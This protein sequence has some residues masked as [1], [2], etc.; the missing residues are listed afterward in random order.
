MKKTVV[1]LI[2]SLLIFSLTACSFL[3]KD[4]IGQEQTGEEIVDKV[5]ENEEEESDEKVDSVIRNEDVIELGREL[6][7]F[8]L[9][10]LDGESKS[11]RDYK[12]KIILINF[13]ASWC[14]HCDAEMPDLQKV[15]DENDD[16]LII[17][18]NVGEDKETAQTYVDEGGYD[19]EVLL[20][21]DNKVAEK[22]MVQGL[23]A[24]YF[25]DIDG[26]FLGVQPGFMTYEQMNDLIVYARNP[27][28]V[29]E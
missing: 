1:F 11:L 25:L 24:T 12:D 23:P 2:V 4:G 28:K 15:S 8:T 29:E 27:E 13:W 20:D 19:F 21:Y 7:N 3:E 10:N 9:E 17:A 18:V 14:P 16:I 5:G 22:Y 26:L 6:P